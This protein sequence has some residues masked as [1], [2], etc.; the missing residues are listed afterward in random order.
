MTKLKKKEKDNYIKKNTNLRFMSIIPHIYIHA[1]TEFNFLII[2][3]D[4]SDILNFK[5]T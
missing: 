2:M 5:N 3:C 4:A 1:K